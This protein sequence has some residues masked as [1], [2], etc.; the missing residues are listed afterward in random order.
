M[1]DVGLPLFCLA[2]EALSNAPLDVGLIHLAS[3]RHLAAQYN[4]VSLEPGSVLVNRRAGGAAVVE[5]DLPIAPSLVLVGDG[6]VL[7]IAHLFLLGKGGALAARIHQLEGGFVFEH[8]IH[9][10]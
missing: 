8:L 6:V 9:T 3:V 4:D 1:L 2:Q 10:A 7:K 5:E